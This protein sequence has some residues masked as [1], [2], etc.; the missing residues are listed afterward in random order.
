MQ[1]EAQ[2]PVIGAVRGLVK[3]AHAGDPAS[4][5]CGVRFHLQ[6]V[7]R[8]VRWRDE[9][10]VVIGEGPDI[11]PSPAGLREVTTLWWLESSLGLLSLAAGV[12]VLAKP[13]NS[14]R[15]L[16]VVTGIFVLV[17]GIVQLGMSLSRGTESRGLVALIGALNVIVGILLVRHPI[18]GVTA[19]ALFLGIWLVAA[20]VVRFVLA[21]AYV[22]QRIWR[23]VVALAEIIVGILIVSSPHIRFAT[24]ALFV[25]IGF[26]ING[27][28]LFVLGLAMRMVKQQA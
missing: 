12:V 10:A 3:T 15:A 17:D 26:I 24:L 19:V 9:I 27:V 22:Q 21:F 1:I 13:D 7:R 28:T 23:I 5:A 8:S 20:G 14:L 4:A 25:G 18:A 2:A 11:A 6:R 16:A